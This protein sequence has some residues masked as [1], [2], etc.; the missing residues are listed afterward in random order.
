MAFTLARALRPKSRAAEKC[1]VKGKSDVKSSMRQLRFRSKAAFEF[2]VILCDDVSSGGLRSRVFYMH[3][4]TISSRE[5]MSRKH[6]FILAFPAGNINRRLV[7][8]IARP[9]LEFLT[10]SWPRQC[11][12]IGARLNLSLN[13][14]QLRP[15][16][17]DED[18]VSQ[19]CLVPRQ[20]GISIPC[21]PPTTPCSI[22]QQALLGV[23]K[24]LKRQ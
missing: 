12:I 1:M 6:L 18:V 11:L 13:N 2:F 5:L 9:K 4:S 7:K 21:T 24:S 15:I 20:K 10:G 17:L 3:S 16:S 19:A 14:Y 22:F 23:I 8:Q